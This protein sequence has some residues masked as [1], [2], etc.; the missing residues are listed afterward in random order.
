M[1]SN[2]ENAASSFHFLPRSSVC[3]VC[4]KRVCVCVYCVGSYMYWPGHTFICVCVWIQFQQKSGSES[5]E[6]T[7][8][9]SPFV[10]FFR[11]EKW[12]VN[13]W[14][15]HTYSSTQSHST[16]ALMMYLL[17]LTYYYVDLNLISLRL[18]LSSLNY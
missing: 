5:G 4:I 6:I 8:F 11:C 12:P 3:C 10:S 18:F 16:N 14:C 17:K 9:P 2:K 1:K 7:F 15:T 13:I